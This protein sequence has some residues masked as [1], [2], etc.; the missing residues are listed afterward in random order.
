LS[1]I[2]RGARNVSLESIEKL[3]RALE[4]PAATLFNSDSASHT[5]LSATRLSP[6]E[7]VDILLVED[8]A[9]DA[10]LTL[11]ALGEAHITNRIHV[12]SDGAAALDFVFCT[13]RYSDRDPAHRPELILLDLALPKVDGFT[14]L[15]RL[16][17]DDRTRDIP[18][19]VLTVSRNDRN[20]AISQK[21]GA[22]AYIVKPV[23]FQNLSAVTPQ[24][25]L[26]WAL[27]KAISA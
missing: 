17:S 15:K 16:K 21:L 18:V 23:D 10:Q 20:I 13:G 2:E 8:N 25:S 9:D 22:E 7:V 4:L 24:L 19:V 26:H 27:L 11:R 12:V 14:V 5:P 6:D 1:D 3:A